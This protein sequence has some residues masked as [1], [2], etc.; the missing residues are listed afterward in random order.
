MAVTKGKSQLTGID[1]DQ[2]QRV[3]NIRNDVERVIGLLRQKH[4]IGID[5]QPIDAVLTKDENEPNH[6]WIRL[7][8][9]VVV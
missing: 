2:T 4:S 1:V 5:T 8:L 9:F 6:F 3:A 7:L